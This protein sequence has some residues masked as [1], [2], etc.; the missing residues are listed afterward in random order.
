MQTVVVDQKGRVMLPKRMRKAL[1]TSSGD[2]LL[3]ETS[4]KDRITFRILKPRIKNDRLL[5]MLSKPFHVS[6]AKIKQIDLSRI[7]DEMWMP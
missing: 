1:N 6:K 5:Q 2:R 7:E 4:T 3:V